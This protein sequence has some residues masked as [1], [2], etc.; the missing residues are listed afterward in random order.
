MGLPRRLVALA[1]IVAG[2]ACSPGDDPAPLCA[3]ET[4]ESLSAECGEVPDGCGGTLACGV[5]A[6]DL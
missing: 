4:C 1:A 2:I 6:R 3:P 5:R